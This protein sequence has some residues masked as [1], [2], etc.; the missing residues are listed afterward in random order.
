[1]GTTA[2]QIYNEIKAY[3][4]KKDGCFQN[5]FVG[6]TADAHQCLFVE[7]GLSEKNDTWIYRICENNRAAKNIKE[8][9]LRLGCDSIACGW[10]DATKTIFAY[11]KSSRTPYK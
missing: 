10:D 4:K 1:M 7:H 6:I 3:I 9:L 2:H 11:P 8:S 5:W